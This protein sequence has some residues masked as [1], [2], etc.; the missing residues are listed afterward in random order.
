MPQSQQI[1]F[2]HTYTLTVTLQRSP[3][4]ESLWS[5]GCQGWLDHRGPCMAVV[6]FLASNLLFQPIPFFVVSEVL[7]RVFA[8]DLAIVMGRFSQ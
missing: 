2:A 7:H 3:T 8:L 6:V 5:L 4:A 1:P